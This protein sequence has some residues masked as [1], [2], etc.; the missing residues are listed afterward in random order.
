M[1]FISIGAHWSLSREIEG[2]RRV[3]LTRLLLMSVG[4]VLGLLAVGFAHLADIRDASAVALFLIAFGQVHA[5]A[6]VVL[7]LKSQ[8]FGELIR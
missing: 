7:L 5:P 2:E 1:L 8:R 3:R 4:T 6:A